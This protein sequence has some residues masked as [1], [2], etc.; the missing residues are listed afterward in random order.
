MDLARDLP[1][2]L[3]LAL[4]II[5]AVVLGAGEA[6][7]LRVDRVRIEVRADGGSRRA[8]ALL[9]LLDDLPRVLNSVL[10]AVLLVQIGAATVTGIL[11]DR[12]FGSLGVTVGSVALTVV[13][14]VYAEAIPKTYAVR[15]PTKVA[16]ALSGL[17]RT[18]SLVFR[19]VITVLVWFA[20]LQA[21]GEGIAP[22]ALDD[23]ELLRLAAE[24]EAAGMIER[25]DRQLMEAGFRLGDTRVDEILV[26]RTDV[27]AVDRGATV[28][29][30]FEHAVAS[31]H[32]RLPV[33]DGDLDRIVGVVRLREL[34]RAV[35]EGAGTVTEVMRPVLTVPER[36]RV[37]ELLPEMQRHRLHLAVAVDEYGGTA[38]IVTIEDIVEEVLGAVADEDEPVSTLVR[39]MG[40]QRWHVAGSCPVDQ[41]E[42]T[43]D[44]AL[45]T[46]DWHTVAGMLLGVTGRILAVGDEVEV[47]DALF[48]VTDA[49][50]TRI[51]HVDVST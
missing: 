30:A 10:L 32:R 19:P 14:F 5:T 8:A 18:L 25:S 22:T 28:A 4:L 45:P 15:H 9:G 6:A 43:L 2:L 38:G 29:E 26:P 27:V 35:S 1:L 36:K 20:D 40:H 47:A 39:S 17:L 11:T 46:G 23:V 51:E 42:A 7:L 24:S 44:R 13:L 41:L 12:W 16:L 48:V 31:G 49:S 37:V 21:P 33:H 34:A 3:A 50:E